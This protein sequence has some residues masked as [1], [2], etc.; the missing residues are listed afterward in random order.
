MLNKNPR[1]IYLIMLMNAKLT[2][3]QGGGFHQGIALYK[4]KGFYLYD[5]FHQIHD[6]HQYDESPQ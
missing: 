3:Q 1:V 5:E 6:F 2:S 4:C